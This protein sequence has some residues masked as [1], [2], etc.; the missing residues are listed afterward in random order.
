LIEIDY[1]KNII[2]FF[3]VML[4]RGTVH[5]ARLVLALQIICGM[6]ALVLLL[7]FN[8]GNTL[9][10]TIFLQDETVPTVKAPTAET[11]PQPTETGLTWDVYHANC[12][13]PAWEKASVALTQ[14]ILKIKARIKV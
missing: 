5:A 2:L 7:L 13:Q 12:H 1:V 14:V 11:M 6:V 9:G 3:V 8:K 4:Q 10:Q